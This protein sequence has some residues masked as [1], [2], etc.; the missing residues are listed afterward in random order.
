MWCVREREIEIE[1]ESEA[2]R[3]RGGVRERDNKRERSLR[4]AHEHDGG[5]AR[6]RSIRC[7]SM[8]M[9]KLQQSDHWPPAGLHSPSPPC[10]R[11]PCRMVRSLLLVCDVRAVTMAVRGG[12]CGGDDGDDASVCVRE[13]ES[14]WQRERGGG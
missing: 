14:Q 6:P 5:G 1:R 10:L 9:T 2:T 4:R 7:T 11:P 8:R 3:E 12:G 13:W